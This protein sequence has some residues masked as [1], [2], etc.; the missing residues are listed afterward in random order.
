[1]KHKTIV[2]AI[3]LITA[4]STLVACK[5]SS[6]AKYH[7]EIE[8]YSMNWGGYERSY[9]VHLPPAQKMAS[10]APLLFVLHG[11]GGTAK[12]MPGFT[13]GR[14]NELAD[15]DGFIVVYPQGIEKQWNDGRIG[16]Q[17]KAWKENIDDVGFIVKI[18]ESLSKEYN[19]DQERIF[20]SGISNGGF[21]SSRLLCDRP[22]VFRGGAVLTATISEDYFPKCQP[23]QPAAVL[24][25]NGTED[26]LVPYNGGPVKVLN[27]TRGTVLSTD[28][29]VN[30]WMEKNGCTTKKP[31][32]NLPDK[33]D[34]GTTVTIQEYTDCN[35]R[36][37]LIL[38]T[39]KGGGH[40]WP[41]GIQYL[42]ERLVGKT[43]REIIACDVIWEYF[44]SLE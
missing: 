1:M 39:I 25:M 13:F 20:T 17:T 44:N 18:V 16:D 7:D 34:D 26:T 21:M 43:S 6:Y 15:Q 9:W 41:G 42:G 11:G 23:A 38:Y 24:I 5:L 37:S 32:V 40:T 27:K 3:V 35:K 19:I 30:F 36:G 28:D 10:P 22:D 14:F 2:W 8:K 12:G 29:Y 33:K 31:M 4:G